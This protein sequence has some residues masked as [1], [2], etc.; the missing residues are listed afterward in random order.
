M[1]GDRLAS[2]QN[3][4]WYAADSPANPACR[5]SISK[6]TAIARDLTLLA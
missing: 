4:F 5:E 2:K 1:R 6:E 3:H